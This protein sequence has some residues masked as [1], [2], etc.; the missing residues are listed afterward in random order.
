MEMK[1]IL[2]M[3]VMAVM[4][5]NDDNDGDG[6]RDEEGCSGGSVIWQSLIVKEV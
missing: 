2:M 5:G 3:V 6:D 1:V 4:A